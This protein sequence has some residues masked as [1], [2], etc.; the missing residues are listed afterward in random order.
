MTDKIIRTLFLDIGGVLLTN[1]WGRKGFVEVAQSLGMNGIQY[2][3]LDDIKSKL[4]AFKFGTDD[5]KS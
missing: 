3:G 1:G 5:G 2:I 4:S